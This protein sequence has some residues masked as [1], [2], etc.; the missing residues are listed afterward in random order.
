MSKV[1]MAGKAA[2][3]S[4]AP[5]ESLSYVDVPQPAQKPLETF[6]DKFFRK[7]TENPLVPIGV[8]ATIAVLVSGVWQMNKGNQ[9]KSQ[10]MMRLRVLFQGLTVFALIGGVYY[11]TTKSA[12]KK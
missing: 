9:A 6:G 12:A 7:T 4:Q 2:E 1:A 5:S 8:A 3:K 11:G 10:R